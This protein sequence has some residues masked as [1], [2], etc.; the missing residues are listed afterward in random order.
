MLFKQDQHQ[1]SSL[2]SAQDLLEC[3]LVEG[4]EVVATSEPK[5][6]PISKGLAPELV[7]GRKTKFKIF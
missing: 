7:S 2:N 3:L 4:E 5:T 1:N 6:S